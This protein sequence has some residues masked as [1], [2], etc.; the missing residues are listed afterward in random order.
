MRGF[1]P[2]ASGWMETCDS[3]LRNQ[4][5]SA[6]VP[7]IYHN[8]IARMLYPGRTSFQVPPPMSGLHM[9]PPMRTWPSYSASMSPPGLFQTC[10]RLSPGDTDTGLIRA[11]CTRHVTASNLGT[12]ILRKPSIVSVAQGSRQSDKRTEARISP[13]THFP[14]CPTLN[15]HFFFFFFLIPFSCALGYRT[16]CSTPLFRLLPLLLLSPATI[17]FPCIL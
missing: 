15:A 9:I 5:S 3:R 17:S 14:K 12:Q 1:F 13:S 8:Y 11:E 10:F 6:E 4:H 2:R 16:L 7:Q